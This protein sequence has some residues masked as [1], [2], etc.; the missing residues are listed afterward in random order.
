MTLKVEVDTYFWSKWLF[1][2]NVAKI[3]NIWSFTKQN[4]R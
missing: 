3:Y 4:M 1:L 2:P